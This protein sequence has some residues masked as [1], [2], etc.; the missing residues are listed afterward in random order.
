[1]P[2]RWTTAL[3]ALRCRSSVAIVAPK[4]GSRARLQNM[5][6]GRTQPCETAAVDVPEICFADAGGVSIAWQQFGSGPDVIAI[7]P[8]MSNIELTWEHEY[9]RRFFDYIARHVRITAF[10]KRGIGLSDKFHEAPTL[11]QRTMDILAVMDAARLDRPSVVGASEGGLMAQ[12]FAAQH[13]ERVD[14][15]VLLNTNPGRAGMLA[16]HRDPDGS[17]DRL[18]RLAD[19]FDTLIAK[20][21]TDPQYSVDLFCPSNSNNAAFV[22]WYGRL[23][24]QSASHTDIRRQVDSI[25]HLDAG[26]FLAQITAPTLVVHATGDP[27]IPVAG[28]R[29]IAERIPDARFVEVPGDDHFVEATPHWQEFTDTWLEFVTGSRPLHQ[30]ERRLM[31]VVFTDIVDST[32]QTE[33]VGD[34]RWRRLLDSH[35]RIAWEIIDRHRGTIVKSTGDGVLARFDAP[36]H[37]MEFSLDF[38]RALAE[39][40]IQIRCGL[41]TGEVEIR[42]N[43]DIVGTAVNLA[44]RVE[45]AADDG[46]I[47]VSSTVRDLVQ[48]G[49]TRFS[50]RGEHRLHGFDQPWHLYAL[51][52]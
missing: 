1:M 40:G 5:D 23:E 8:L 3:L 16:V 11:E 38:R 29:Y 4:A 12:L 45:Q 50:D 28:G 2:V 33:A 43:G 47:L 7:P 36:S 19:I 9:Y 30:T 27:V 44:A 6:D 32:S 46:T 17:L 39:L 21:G 35:D 41:H 51:T 10:D 15:L 48:G 42:E 20:W 34:G 22:R 25:V 26:P 49:Q 24:R 14:R 31:T 18:K 13:P 37:A 52:E